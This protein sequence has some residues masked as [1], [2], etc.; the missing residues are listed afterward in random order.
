MWR[1]RRARAVHAVVITSEIIGLERGLGAKGPRLGHHA[2]MHGGHWHTWHPRS[3]HLAFSLWALALQLNPRL[4]AAVSV[5]GRPLNLHRW[6][7]CHIGH[8][9][10]L[11]V[12]AHGPLALRPNLR[13]NLRWSSP[14][15]AWGRRPTRGWRALHVM[16]QACEVGTVQQSK[17]N[18]QACM[19]CSAGRGAHGSMAGPSPV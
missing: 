7:R 18:T 2:F 4:S 1:K 12:R 19:P 6:S 11:G 10:P 8:A 3:R 15:S 5:R 13:P 16:G 14:V 9:L 17:A